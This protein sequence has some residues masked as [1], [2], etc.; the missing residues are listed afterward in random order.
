MTTNE[1]MNKWVRSRRG[2]ANERLPDTADAINAAI[3]EATG[4]ASDEESEP[5]AAA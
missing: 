5:D 1:A 2:P 4:R 3:R